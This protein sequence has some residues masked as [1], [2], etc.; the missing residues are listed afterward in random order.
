V[1][2]HSNASTEFH[3]DFNQPHGSGRTCGM[4]QPVLLTWASTA[5]VLAPQRGSACGICGSAGQSDLHLISDLQVGMRPVARTLDLLRSR[6]ET[7][8]EGPRD[9][10]DL[11]ANVLEVAHERLAPRLHVARPE[12]VLAARNRTWSSARA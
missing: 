6:Y 3:Q 12:V 10:A 11:G 5:A 4:R 8:L 7:G 1:L 9:M 2:W